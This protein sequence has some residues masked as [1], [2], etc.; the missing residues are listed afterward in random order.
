M[1]LKARR[2]EPAVEPVTVADLM[3][4]RME[5]LRPAERKVARTLLAA[6]P[7]AGLNTVADLAQRA[8]VSAPS[9]VRYAH[10]LGFE[11]FPALQAALRAEL[12]RQYNGPLA[13]VRREQ[14]PGTDMESLVSR[15]EDLSQRIL[16]SFA[17]IPPSDL[18]TTIA[19]LADT[20]RPLYVVGGRFTHVL[21]EYLTILLEHLRPRV[22][23]LADPFGADHGQVLDLTRRDVF[24]IIDVARYQR[25]TMALAQEIRKRG[26]TIVLITDERLSPVAAC[27]DAVL[28]TAVAT[29]AA[30]PSITPAFML[31]ELLITPVMKRI[32]DSAQ[33]RLALWEDSW[34]RHNKFVFD[35]EGT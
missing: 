25:D 4:S 28:P 1:T 14:E 8:A 10:A 11:G 19:L 5:Q 20:S 17:A 21:A 33:T 27:A 34:H 6:Y 29:P 24:V 12:T 35:E 30:D 16:A 3:R 32:G 15:T 7:S 9:V 31:C 13:H 22:H 18:D 23:F 26:V 2:K